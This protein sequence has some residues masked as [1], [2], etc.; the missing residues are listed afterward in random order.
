MSATEIVCPGCGT[1]S[2]FDQVRRSSEEFCRRCDYPLFWVR[3]GDEPAA[4]DLAAGDTGL[5]RLPGAAGHQAV[6]AL[7]CPH[8]NEP[9]LHTATVCIR[10]GGDMRP[11][12]PPPAPSPPP[13]VVVPV[14]LPPP[15]P[16]PEPVGS[17]LPQMVALVVLFVLTMVLLAVV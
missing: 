11:V 8:C 15:P 5:R 6:A 12:A 10:C 4:V 1:V 17:E 14:A 2:H 16:P 7:G 9:N 13:V 3:S